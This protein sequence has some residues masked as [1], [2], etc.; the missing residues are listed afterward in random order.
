MTSLSYIY[1]KFSLNSFATPT[2]SKLKFEIPLGLIFSL[3]SEGFI[4]KFVQ[5]VN[6][7]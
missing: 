1:G 7:I 2:D 6:Q 4:H 5:C 3:K